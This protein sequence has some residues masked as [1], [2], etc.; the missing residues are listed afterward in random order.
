MNMQRFTRSVLSE[1][2]DWR[3]DIKGHDT[4]YDIDPVEMMVFIRHEYLTCA[5]DLINSEHA[6]DRAMAEES[7]DVAIALQ[8]AI[9]SQI[10]IVRLE[11]AHI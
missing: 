3:A 11:P 7:L 8:Q 10:D 5:Y 9:E 2:N 6:D 4:L 1:N